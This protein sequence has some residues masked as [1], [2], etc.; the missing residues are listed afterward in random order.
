MS[1]PVSTAGE[2]ETLLLKHIMAMPTNGRG[3]EETGRCEQGCRDPVGEEERVSP[4]SRLGESQDVKE[5]CNKGRG[6]QLLTEGK[7]S[8]EVNAF[9]QG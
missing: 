4:L 1:G 9:Y 3:Q 7:T 6:T 8:L 5:Q 2:S